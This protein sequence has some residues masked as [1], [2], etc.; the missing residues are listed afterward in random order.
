M[1]T[2]SIDETEGAIVATAA[3]RVQGVR[4]ALNNKHRLR[5]TSA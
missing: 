5:N 3:G 2:D 1:I 4:N